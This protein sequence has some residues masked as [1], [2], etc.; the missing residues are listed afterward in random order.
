MWRTG[1]DNSDAEAFFRQLAAVCRAGGNHLANPERYE[2]PWHSVMPAQPGAQTD[3]LA[4]PQYFFSGDGQLA[5][6]LVRPVKEQDSFTFS[7]KSIDALRA[8][9]EQM[10][11]KFPTLE[12]GLTG[13]PVLENDEMIASQRDSSRASWLAV[14]GVLVMFLIA[15]RGLRY[16]LMTVSILLVGNVWALGWL[17]LTVG[18]LDILSSA[19]AVMLIGIGDYGVLWV[20]RFSQER[21]TG[22]ASADAMRRTGMFVGPSILTAAT[23]T[24]L[25]FFAAMLADLKAVAELGWIAGSGVLL[26]AGVLRGDARAAVAVRL[27]REEDVNGRSRDVAV[28]CGAPR[29][30]APMAA[31]A[32]APALRSRCRERSG[33]AGAGILRLHT[34]YDHNLLHLQSPQMASVQWE[35]TLIDHTAGMSWH[36]VSYTTTPEEALALKAR[37]EQLPAVSRVVELASLVPREQ[38]RKR[39]MLAD[40]QRRLKRLPPRG[41]LIEHPQPAPARI[42]S[43]A[44]A[45]LDAL[46]VLGTDSPSAAGELAQSIRY[47]LGQLRQASA[48]LAR[49]RRCCS[50]RRSRST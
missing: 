21:R 26:C 11:T 38:G 27:P 24:A 46:A 1:Q 29:C 4:E 8:L 9:V 16:P 5:S 47:L 34:S 41:I 28:A 18:H 33:D 15:Y 43:A 13:L 22:L 37:F 3:L 45:L 40:I 31:V 50:S 32:D 39:E 2:N 42:E 20:M 14:G 17:T 6:L 35:Q 23:T 19:F 48:G 44:A 25:A 49:A 12:F 7:Q 36:A 10:R 30:P